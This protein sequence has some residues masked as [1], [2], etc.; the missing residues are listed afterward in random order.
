[1]RNSISIIHNEEGS[2]IAIVL[3][4]MAVFTVI[5]IAAINTSVSES[6]I[7]RNELCYRSSFFRA[8]AAAVEA[9]QRL[10]DDN[11]LDSTPPSFLNPI[12]TVNA[13][14]QLPA[15]AIWDATARS[16]GVDRP[17][18]KTEFIAIARGIQSGSSMAQ[19]TA[20]VHS[21]VIYGRDQ[22]ACGGETI[23]GMGY[24][25]PF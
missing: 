8:E 13:D 18:T 19:G 11:N 25:K 12:G 14:N 1:M 4:L 6:Q 2:L 5:G 10:E 23:I 24:V 15:A 17:E 7:V 20:Q 3:L 21:Y 9:I 22:G 16:A